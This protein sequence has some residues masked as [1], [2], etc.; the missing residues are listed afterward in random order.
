MVE[1][2]EGPLKGV[3][4]VNAKPLVSSTSITTP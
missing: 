2:A 3:L 1:V 4:G